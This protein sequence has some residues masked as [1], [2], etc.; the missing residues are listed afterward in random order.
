MA[1]WKRP[2][3]WGGVQADVVVVPASGEEDR[4]VTV[5]LRDLEAEAVP[6]E[7]EG[8]FDVRDLQVNVT[9]SGTRVYDPFGALASLHRRSSYRMPVPLILPPPAEGV[10]DQ[11]A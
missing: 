7:A 4:V 2:A 11:D 5:P 8:P 10:D 3:E 6:V 1:R 9:Y